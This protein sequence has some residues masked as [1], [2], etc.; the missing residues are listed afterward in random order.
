V[1]KKSLHGS[2]QGSVVS[3]IELQALYTPAL[4]AS[5]VAGHWYNARTLIAMELKPGTSLGPYTIRAPLG[6]GGMG[7]VYRASDTKLGRDVALKFLPAEFA[8]DPGRM[9]RFQ[10]EAQVLASL[11]HSTSAVC[12][13]ED[14]NA[15]KTF[16]A[17]I[18]LHAVRR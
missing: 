15:A 11:N 14:S 3:G 5:I 1:D 4:R 2:P 6:Q 7:V 16:S 9:A 10:R 17:L 12:S 8:D 13:S 18:R